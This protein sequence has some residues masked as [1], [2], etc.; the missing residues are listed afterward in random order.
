MGDIRKGCSNSVIKKFFLYN[1]RVIQ[2]LKYQ[3][4]HLNSA[5]SANTFACCRVSE[6]ILIYIVP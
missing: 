4:T 2:G 3:F 5:A 6:R 1:K